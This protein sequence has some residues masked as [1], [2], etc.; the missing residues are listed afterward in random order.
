MIL[1]LQNVRD[2]LYS[3]PDAV[4]ACLCP[5]ELRSFRQAVDTLLTAVIQAGAAATT[6]A[7]A[8]VDRREADTYVL[9]VL[10][11]MEEFLETVVASDSSPE[12]AIDAVTARALL[13][14]V[15]EVLYSAFPG[16]SLQTIFD[17][18]DEHA[19]VCAVTSFGQRLMDSSASM[20][21]WW[22]TNQQ[23]V[24]EQ[25][26]TGLSKASERADEGGLL[27]EAVRRLLYDSRTEKQTVFSFAESLLAKACSNVLIRGAV[28]AFLCCDDFA[29]LCGTFPKEA[30]RILASFVTHETPSRCSPY[31]LLALAANLVHDALGGVDK[32]ALE[33]FIQ[34]VDFLAMGSVAFPHALLASFCWA[35]EAGGELLSSHQIIH[36]KRANKPKQSQM[37]V[38]RSK[39]LAVFR[40]LHCLAG[41]EK[42]GVFQSDDDSG[43]L[44]CEEVLIGAFDTLFSGGGGFYN[45]VLGN[46]EGRRRAI[47]APLVVLHAE[48]AR[49]STVQK[50]FLQILVALANSSSTREQHEASKFSRFS[51]NGPP[52]TAEQLHASLCELSLFFNDCR[53]A[54][55]RG[56]VAGSMIH[57]GIS[58]HGAELFDRVCGLLV[59]IAEFT[60]AGWGLSVRLGRL[61]GAS[62]HVINVD[63]KQLS[64]L[65]AKKEPLDRFPMG[66]DA[67]YDALDSYCTERRGLPSNW[68][69]QDIAGMIFYYYCFA[70]YPLDDFHRWVKRGLSET[71]TGD[72]VSSPS[73]A[74]VNHI[75]QHFNN[76]RSGMAGRDEIADIGF[77]CLQYSQIFAVQIALQQVSKY[78]LMIRFFSFATV[79]LLSISLLKG[80]I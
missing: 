79:Q 30:A 42:L 43:I 41:A 64:F 56:H 75:F 36:Q 4:A 77:K 3:P 19:F 58:S 59:K 49:G 24:L 40:L 60:S 31:D 69:T 71:D 26:P 57:A 9:K 27:L 35:E 14:Q 1:R 21:R 8:E 38:G 72:D 22:K 66:L 7:S 61:A 28:E 48:F 80:K 78:F 15:N 63:K 16:Y 10:Q 25:L 50:E 52:S 37:I 13:P 53:P 65:L 70:R 6:S 46:L 17:P 20:T 74:E 39:A 33:E 12:A 32:Y 68:K 51:Y 62:Y 5:L 2:T 11:E 29:R 18:F 47:V 44:G 54:A 67:V 55:K 23:A 34:R 45:Q 76:L 73:E